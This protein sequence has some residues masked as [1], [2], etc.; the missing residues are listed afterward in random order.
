MVILEKNT[1]TCQVLEVGGMLVCTTNT[2]GCKYYIVSLN[3]FFPAI[4]SPD[5]PTEDLRL[6]IIRNSHLQ[7]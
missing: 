7:L 2:A 3:L 1:I 5:N 4:R 6:H